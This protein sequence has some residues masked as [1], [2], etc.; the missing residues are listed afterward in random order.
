[1]S[2]PPLCHG[3]KERRGEERERDGSEGIDS[4]YFYLV[5]IKLCLSI[6]NCIENWH[7]TSG[8]DLSALKDLTSDQQERNDVFR[9]F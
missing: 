5:L 3:G 9:C 8:Q 4:Q 6:A 2:G 1:M 7:R